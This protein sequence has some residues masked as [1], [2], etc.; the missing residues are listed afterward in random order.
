M[1]QMTEALQKCYWEKVCSVVMYSVL[2]CIQE[3]EMRG[4][5][6]NVIDWEPYS[7]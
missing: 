3:E 4:V 2:C 1:D 6:C 7:Y 5:K